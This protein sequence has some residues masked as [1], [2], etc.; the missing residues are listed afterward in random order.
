MAF[1]VRYDSAVPVND[2]SLIQYPQ[3]GIRYVYT[4]LT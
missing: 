1:V 3:K 2:I 4:R